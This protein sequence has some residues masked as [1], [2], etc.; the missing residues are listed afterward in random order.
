M[1]RV[2]AE[3]D[4][5]DFGCDGWVDKFGILLEAADSLL[6]SL[7]TGGDDIGG[8]GPFGSGRRC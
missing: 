2:G 7:E 8:G 4:F 1:E 3:A 5:F 6:Q